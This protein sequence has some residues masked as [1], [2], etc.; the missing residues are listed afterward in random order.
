M[1][2]PSCCCRAHSR[3]MLTSQHWTSAHRCQH[4]SNLQATPIKTGDNHHDLYIQIINKSIS[5]W[6]VLKVWVP[7]GQQICSC[8]AIKSSIFAGPYQDITRHHHFVR[9]Q[10][11][12]PCS[13]LHAGAA[14]E[15]GL[16]QL[17]TMPW[18]RRSRRTKMI[19]IIVWWWYASTVPRVQSW[20]MIVNSSSTLHSH[21]P[22]SR[23]RF[24]CCA[25]SHLISRPRS[26]HNS[27]VMK[28][29]FRSTLSK[30]S[31]SFVS[32]SGTFELK[33]SFILSQWPWPTTLDFQGVLR[34]FVGVQ[35]GWLFVESVAEG[36]M[37]SL[38]LYVIKWPLHLQLQMCTH[39][40]E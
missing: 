20:A 12:Q 18:R 31:Q 24:G 28:A 11:P 33:I 15:V 26:R 6:H 13:A 40:I 19:T 10:G 23:Q 14:S 29:S 22:G 37:F 34:R 17:T 21:I 38:T 8:L 1:V 30:V 9:S 25:W 35:Q 3:Q 32:L 5:F 16:K 7:G 4:K 2:D 27:R 36:K 39:H